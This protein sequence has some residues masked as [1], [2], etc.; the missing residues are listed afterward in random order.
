MNAPAD[1]STARRRPLKLG[2][3]LPFAETMANGATPRWTDL[4]TM[5]RIA[6]DIGFDSLWVG[7][8]LL[9]H[10][11]TGTFGCWEAWSMLTALAAVTH[12]VTLGPLVAC[13]S[14]R[15]PALL[16]KMA[17]TVDEISAGRLVLGIG[18]G[19]HEP[20]YRAFG[21]PFEQRVSQFAEAVH[22]IH[23]LLRTGQVDFAGRYYQARD[24]ELRP[25]GPQ[26]NRLQLLIGANGPRMLRLA[27]RY[28]DIWN[29]DWVLPQDIPERQTACDVA[30][31]EIGRDST[32][33][34]RTT[35]VR[36]DLPG[37]E[38]EPFDRFGGQASGE[39]EQLAALLRAYADVG[40][41]HL[42]IC[43]G[44]NTPAG[45]E[46]FAPVLELLDRG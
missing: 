3:F 25:R 20:E 31:Q 36:I 45:V 19:W 46:A 38:H 1:S 39:P 26:A 44:P 5:A 7:D 33:L 30:C 18:A 41:S 12:R 2:L 43:L 27:A 16:A 29:T 37:V 13:T 6:E 32:T 9:A 35:S 17:D 14:Y 34:E 40:I 15:N 8:H 4:A 11:P 28:A 23:T 21:Y 10:F 24:C 22:I 42:Q